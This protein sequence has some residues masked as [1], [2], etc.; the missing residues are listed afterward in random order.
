MPNRPTLITFMQL[1]STL[2]RA[3]AA[4]VPALCLT[5]SPAVR[6]GEGWVTNFEEAKTAAAKDNKDILMDFTGSDWCGWC[7]KLQKEVFTTDG[8][9]SV[10]PKHFVLLELDF[11]QNKELPKE[12]KEQNEKLQEKYAI[13][14]F[15]TIMLT[16]AKGR[17]YAKT[18]YMPGGPEAYNTHLGDLRK[19]REARDAEF[20]KA[21]AASGL[22][23]AKALQA[24]LK[25]LGPD[26]ASAYYQEEIDQIIALDT[27][28]TLGLKAK[29]VYGVKRQ[30]LDEQLQK[31]AAEQKTKEFGEAIDA[32][33]IAEKITGEDLQDLMMT[34]LQ[35]L[36]PADLEKADALMDAV[37]KVDPKTEL[38]GRAKEI[39]GSIVEMRKQVD[40][41]KNDP[42]ADGE[43][44]REA[45]KAAP[46]EKPGK[47]E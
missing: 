30:D 6:A 2:W 10:S 23:K 45:E 35:I 13:E 39:K 47:G 43:A 12:L 18:G 3:L 46:A 9:K 36:G 34:K 25:T 32:F 24:G 40:K 5:F 17:P 8:F 11:P 37:I 22:D 19:I 41:S 31:F 20:K 27:E 15:P 4:S 16:D 38:A 14:G 1:F 42:A 26:V 28:D 21:E 7:I 44:P 33:I 29:R